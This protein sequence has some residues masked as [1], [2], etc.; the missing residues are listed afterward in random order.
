MK[1]R[2]NVEPF[3]LKPVGK[4]NLWGG[5][6]LKDDFGKELGVFPLAESWEC[7]THPAGES[8][9]DSG[10]YKGKKLMEVL[11]EHPEYIGSHPKI[12][13]NQIPVLVKFIDAA[14]DLS[15]QVHPNDEYARIH[16]NGS[17]GKTEMW[18][19]VDAT[20]DAFIIYGFHHQVTKKQIRDAIATGT[21]EKY[22]NIIHV[23]PGEVY[24]I[25]SGTVHAIGKGC[26]IA[27]IQESSDLTYR[28]YDYNRVD[29]NGKTRE[30]HI[31]KGL[32]VANLEPMI[33]PRQPLNVYKYKPGRASQLLANCEYFQVERMIVNTERIKK[34]VKFKTGSLTF[35][36]LVCYHGCGV[37]IDE[38]ADSSITFFKGDTIFVPANSDNLKIHGK[39][40]F[41][42]IRC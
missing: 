6:R 34:L 15:I 23:K 13:N 39:A 36:I 5:R 7:S 18:Y 2:N 1:S 20:E 21:L 9:V 8:I 35:Q 24:F 38:Q 28:L 27:E 40:E 16:E 32:D 37:I 10:I 12:V 4:D 41:L 17:W 19:I 14:K 42:K 3:L 33:K 25:P 31:D 22:M 26:L 29:K 30:L 11:N